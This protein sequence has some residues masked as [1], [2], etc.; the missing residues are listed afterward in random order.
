M[1]EKLSLALKPKEEEVGNSNNVSDQRDIIIGAQTP[2]QSLWAQFRLYA[3]QPLRHGQVLISVPW[4]II[5]EM[6]I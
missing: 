1:C 6:G 5:Y 3:H 2:E 4:Y